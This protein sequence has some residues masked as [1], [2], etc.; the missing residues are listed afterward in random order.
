MPHPFGPLD[1]QQRSPHP[2]SRVPEFCFVHSADLHLGA[3]RWLRA[4]PNDPK[5]RWRVQ[6]ADRLAFRGLLD[7]CV[8]S[9]ARFLLCAGDIIDGWCRDYMV[10]LRFADE[11]LR[12]R[13][14]QCQV[15]LLLGNHDLRSRMLRSLPLP[16]FVRIVGLNGPETHLFPELKVAVHGWSAPSVVTGTD[17]AALF[18]PPLAGY[19]NIGLLHTSADGR[20]GHVD[21][22]PTSRLTLRHHGYQYWAL[23]HVHQ[24]EVIA[25][26]PWIV[27]PGNLQAR[28]LRESGEKGATLVHVQGTEIASV[29]HASVDALRFDRLTIDCEGLDHFAQILTRVGAKL[30]AYQVSQLTI[31]RVEIHGLRAA[32]CLLQVPAARRARELLRVVAEF[33]APQ[34]WVDELHVNTGTELGAWPLVKAA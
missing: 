33:R 21:Y 20:K 25:Q 14:T 15:L 5:L 7:L 29:E 1:G 27:F 9:Q 16:D 32:A 13:A 19:L 12:L 28:G 23:G 2:T 4:L 22:A 6:N 30:C 11:L 31:L 17:T 24:R 18:P 10:A 8:A 26:T 3:K 34:V